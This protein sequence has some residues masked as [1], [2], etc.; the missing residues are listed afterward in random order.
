MALVGLV[1][2]ATKSFPGEEKFGLCM[3]MRRC[4]VSIPSNIAEGQMR[5][6]NK[7]FKQ[8]ISI[9]RGSCAELETQNQLAHDIGFIDDKMYS[10]LHE[11]IEWCKA[12]RKECVEIGARAKELFNETSTPKKLIEHLVS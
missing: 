1:Y 8:F 12:N 3:Q 4:A 10:D 7:M 2:K 5:P 9:S 6:T 11:K